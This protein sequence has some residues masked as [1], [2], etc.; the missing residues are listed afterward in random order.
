MRLVFAII[1]SF[2]PVWLPVEVRIRV[3]GVR[4]WL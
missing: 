4:M 2:Q 3:A 1:A